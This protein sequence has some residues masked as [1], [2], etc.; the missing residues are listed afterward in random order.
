MHGYK[1]QY[2]KN[3]FKYIP[4]LLFAATAVFATGTARAQDPA[5]HPLE[6]Y[7]VKY[8]TEGNAAGEKIQFSQ[9]YGRKI[10]LK[11][12]LQ[13]TMPD[14]GSVKRKNGFLDRKRGALDSGRK[15][16]RQYRHEV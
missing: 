4:C 10:C 9:D 6:S 5:L 2:L 11:E 1:T 13:I 8:K 16:R 3:C 12:N 15:P 7:T 14:I